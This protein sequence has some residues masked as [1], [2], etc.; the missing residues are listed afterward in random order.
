[1]CH[2]FLHSS[3]VPVVCPMV[4]V[5]KESSEA[6]SDSRPQPDSPLSRGF[7]TGGNSGS[8]EIKQSLFI[9]WIQFVS[10]YTPLTYVGVGELTA[11]KTPLFAAPPPL[12]PK[13]I[14]SS[15][16]YSSESSGNLSTDAPWHLFCV[17]HVLN[18]ILINH[19]PDSS[20]PIYPM[21][22]LSEALPPSISTSNHRLPTEAPRCLTWTMCLARWTT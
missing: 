21:A 11:A 18:V 13:K 3:P 20:Q 2:P 14:P 22:E 17:L 6:W 7:P 9:P 12:P 4:V 19:L 5:P 1:M 10:E 8:H 16:G 15:H